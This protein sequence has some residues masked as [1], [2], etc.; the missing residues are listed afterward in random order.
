MKFRH[1]ND[2]MRT[3]RVR[4]MQELLGKKNSQTPLKKKKRV[5]K[6]ILCR[7]KSFQGYDDLIIYRDGTFRSVDESVDECDEWKLAHSDLGP[8]FLY[9]T[10]GCTYWETDWN[11]DDKDEVRLAN[12]IAQA[13][14][15]LEMD[16]ILRGENV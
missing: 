16:K 8:I 6:R 7:I 10:E 13:L 1:N 5:R 2:L 14:A 3:I 12:T 9:K 11:S 15:D 4:E